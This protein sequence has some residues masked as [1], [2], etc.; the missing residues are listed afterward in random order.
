MTKS[1][2]SPDPKQRY[3]IKFGSLSDF[4]VN[5]GL[6]FQFIWDQ[7]LH[8]ISDPDPYRIG[9]FFSSYFF[10][11]LFLNFCYPTPHPDE[12]ATFF[13]NITD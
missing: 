12:F 13:K 4:Q 10:P 9:L 11:T 3:R 8:V 5:P 6:I 1:G 2:I 7:T